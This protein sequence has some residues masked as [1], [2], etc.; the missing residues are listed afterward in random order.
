MDATKDNKKV[1]KQE[2]NGRG[3]KDALNA[4]L[5]VAALSMM[6]Y[7]TSM[8]GRGAKDAKFRWFAIDIMVQV[9]SVKIASD[10]IPHGI[11]VHGQNLMDAG[12][13]VMLMALLVLVLIGDM[14]GL[15]TNNPL[16]LLV[17]GAQIGLFFAILIKY[18]T[19]IVI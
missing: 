2:A 3:F 18:L 17:D 1:V 10:L 19:R 14:S 7:G 6:V 12:V 8:L 11:A 16:W 9:I 5:S 13:G 15:S 4:F